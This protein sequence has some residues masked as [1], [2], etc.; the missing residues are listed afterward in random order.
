MD[1]LIGV[2]LLNALVCAF[3]GGLVGSRRGA[4]GAGAALGFLFGEIGVLVAFALDNRE[5]CAHCGERINSQ[6]SICPHCRSPIFRSDGVQY[7][8]EEAYSRASEAKRLQQLQR[9]ERER[10]AAAESAAFWNA[11]H[12]A[13][14]H[15]RS[16]TAVWLKRAAIGLKNSGIQFFGYMLWPLRKVDVLIF[17]VAGEEPFTHRT[18][19]TLLVLAVIAAPLLLS[20]LRSRES[21][22]STPDEQASAAFLAQPAADVA[23]PADSPTVVQ[24]TKSNVI[25]AEIPAAVND[26]QDQS[27]VEPVV[28][29]VAIPAPVPVA[30]NEWRTL[31]PATPPFL[32]V[33]NLDR[34]SFQCQLEGFDRNLK[35]H[36]AVNGRWTATPSGIQ[37]E[38]ERAA[39]RVGTANNFQIEGTVSLSKHGGWFWLIGWT[40]SEGYIVY[41]V[42]LSSTTWF[43][44][45]VA[46][47]PTESRQLHRFSR[48]SI[49]GQQQLSVGV[50]DA[51]L[52]FRVGDM[53]FL[54]RFHLPEYKEGEIITGTFLP[55]AQYNS[56]LVTFHRLRM[57]ADD[58][59]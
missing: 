47:N 48:K 21:P 23:V 7:L 1:M 19:Q 24:P 22:E 56:R 25:T 45:R 32:H 15:A 27:Q 20:H 11:R 14:A 6:S 33:G 58:I 9:I 35:D 5:G 31:I 52:T 51:H 54:E 59:R 26:R 36:F 38:G 37:S 41:D 18:L 12:K 57:I 10:V 46:P 44:H 42:G 29:P 43:L 55:P 4:E 40:G 3:L 2:L 13:L 30:I 34:F 17:K 16:A 49:M 50:E 39:L 28:P 8:S 53:T